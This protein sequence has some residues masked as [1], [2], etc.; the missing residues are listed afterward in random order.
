M[1]VIDRRS[2]LKTTTTAAAAGISAGFSINALG[3]NEKVIIGIMGINGRGNYLAHKFLER[4]DVE[5]KY[6]ADPDS[7]LFESRARGIEEKGF[8]RPECVQDFRLMLEDKDV[9]AIVMGTPDHWHAPGTIFA[10]Q[11][12]K[13]V[14]VEKPCHHEPWEGQKMIEAARKYKRV[15]QVGHQNRSAPYIYEAIETIR[16]G[17]IGDVHL[18]RVMNSKARVTIGNEP[19]RPVPDGVDY[20]M[21]LGPCK[22]RPFNNNHF[23]YAWHWFWEYSGGDIIN[24]GVHQMDIARWVSGVKY[25]KSVYSTGGIH[26]FKDD[27]ETPDTHVAVWDFEGMT[28]IFEQELWSP[29]MK[30]APMPIRDGDNLPTWPFIGTRIEISGTRDFMILGRHG[31]GYEV[32]NAEGQSVQKGKSGFSKMERDHIANFID[33]IRSR[34][35]PNGDVQEAHHSALLC[36]YANA[37]YRLGRKLFIDPETEF[38]VNDDEANALIRRPCREPFGVP[39]TV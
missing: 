26:F 30:K 25:P 11:A 1:S 33:C 15:V 13:D 24:D 34:K 16:S 31:S 29:Y 27:Q 37:S 18:V 14:Y 36:Q 2:F 5:V 35:L 17:K 10:C 4:D 38:F 19:D 32:Y 21:W 7:R 3:A 28:M 20:K 8:K 6:L 12:G 22:D 23:H 39:E 9:D